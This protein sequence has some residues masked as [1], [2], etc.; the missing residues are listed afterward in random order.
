M[1]LQAIHDH[2]E[3]LP[4]R[5]K[6]KEALPELPAANVYCKL[7]T[8]LSKPKKKGEKGKVGYTFTYRNI[9][10]VDDGHQEEPEVPKG[11]AKAF[12]I[13]NQTREL[14]VRASKMK[15][16]NIRK[17]FS[18]ILN[19]GVDPETIPKEIDNPFV[20]LTKD[21]V[22]KSALSLSVYNRPDMLARPRTASV[23]IYQGVKGLEPP[24]VD[25]EGNPII[26]EEEAVDERLP[27]MTCPKVSTLLP[28]AKSGHPEDCTM[29]QRTGT[30]Q[31]RLDNMI[32]C[33]RIKEKLAKD[34]C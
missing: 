24:K 13:G 28:V 32:E 21:Q 27:P 25:D 2:N 11:N 18:K 22:T 4:P 3:K 15:I 9:G 7:G 30:E 8:Q 33:E 34:A 16:A 26:V 1:Q 10:M 14:Q 19:A 5:K 20:G 29:I 23:N 31:Q 6:K 12:T 17:N